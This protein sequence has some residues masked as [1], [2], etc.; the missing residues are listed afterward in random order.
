MQR[1]GVELP[2]VQAGMGGGLSGHRLAAAVTAA[3]GLGTIGFLDAAALR[4]EIAAAR[5]LTDGPLAV[6]LL[7]PFARSAHFDAASDADVVVTFWG[8]PQRRTGKLWIHQCGSVEEA[9]SARAA[10]ADAVVAQGVEA[11]GHVRGA[12][13][14]AELLGLLRSTLGADYPVLS[15][16]GMVDRADAEARLAAGAAAVVS[17]TRFLMSEESGAHPAYKERLRGAR[18][19]VLTELFGHLSLA[20]IGTCT[21]DG[22]GAGGDGDGDE[23]TSLVPVATRDVRS[24]D[25]GGAGGADAR[26]RRSGRGACGDRAQLHAA[27]A[28][29]CRDPTST[30]RPRCGR[31]GDGR[32]GCARR[33]PRRGPSPPAGA[34][35]RS[36]GRSRAAR[37]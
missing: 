28:H 10:G 6:N 24:M 30:P 5:G 20:L 21:T 13:P 32:A 16:G 1:I 11:G 12:V 17:G 34:A 29:P 19:T 25:G 27:I 4:G 22:G 26:Q 31:R 9:V 14:A 15:A 36:R 23:R 3:G 7:L 8:R 33:R 18:A 35:A 37:S 2:V